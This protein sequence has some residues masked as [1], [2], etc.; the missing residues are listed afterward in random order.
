MSISRQHFIAIAEVI[1]DSDEF[2]SDE[3][4]ERFA[5][6][7]AREL[8]QFNGRFNR[9]IFRGFIDQR[10]KATALRRLNRAA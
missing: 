10:R 4:R 6:G 3:A 1:A 7:M 2:R 5:D 8:A 9:Q